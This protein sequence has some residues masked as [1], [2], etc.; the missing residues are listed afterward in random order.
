MLSAMQRARYDAILAKLDTALNVCESLGLQDEVAASRF[1]AYR[2]KVERLVEVFLR[3][4]QGKTTHELEASIT[5]E[6]FES[7]LAL[8]ESAE[9]GDIVPFVSQSDPAVLKP[10][11]RDVLRGPALPN[12]ENMNSSQ[13]RNV[14]FELN[15]AHKLWR[16]GLAPRLGEHP[17]LTCEVQAAKFFIECKRPSSIKAAHTRLREARHQRA[18]CRRM[19]PSSHGIGAISLSKVLNP[20]DQ[21][22]VYPNEQAGRDGLHEYLERVA[23]ALRDTLSDLATGPDLAGVVFHAITPG[24]DR[25]A[26]MYVL[27]Q[28]MVLVPM[29]P[30]G[31]PDERAF[32]LFGDALSTQWY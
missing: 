9:L 14:L 5:T 10:K 23:D 19:A 1:T 16:A 7:L 4:A 15:C 31:S 29:K 3:R 25:S 22:F 2:Q 17:D 18:S 30:E 24:F 20:G 6:H 11:L 12:D 8:S 28:H 21:L 26:E 32:R 13:S 27:A